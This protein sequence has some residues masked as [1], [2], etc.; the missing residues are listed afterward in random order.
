MSE[1]LDK[2]KLTVDVGLT[3]PFPGL[4]QFTGHDVRGVFIA[5]GDTVSNYDTAITYTSST[6]NQ[7]KL[8]NPDGYTRWWNPVEFGVFP[9]IFSYTPGALGTSVGR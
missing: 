9:P 2:G 5:P 3:H 6:D 8:L 1:W 4:D 7:P